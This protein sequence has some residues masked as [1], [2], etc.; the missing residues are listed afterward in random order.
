MANGIQLNDTDYA[1]IVLK[2]FDVINQRLDVIDFLLIDKTVAVSRLFEHVQSNTN[3]RYSTFRNQWDEMSRFECVWHPKLW[4]Y[5]ASAEHSTHRAN[6]TSD[7]KAID[8]WDSKILVFQ[9][10]GAH[11]YIIGKKR[12]AENATFCKLYT[13]A[14]S[15]RG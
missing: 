11:P 9:M 12:D 5:A 2:Y 13:D 1:L 15:F 3:E 7:V 8:L 6:E 14:V 10:N 4:L